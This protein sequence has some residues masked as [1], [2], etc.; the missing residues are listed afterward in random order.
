M[1]GNEIKTTLT[2]GRIL[3]YLGDPENPQAGTGLL[4]QTD[5]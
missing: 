1:K 4:R 2:M 5:G 3:D